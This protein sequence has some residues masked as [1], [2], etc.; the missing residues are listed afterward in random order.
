MGV[1]KKI[2]VTG[3]PLA[4]TSIVSSTN[5]F[6]KGN[7]AMSAELM[8]SMFDSIVSNGIVEGVGSELEISAYQG[9][10]ICVL[11][12]SMWINGHM[13]KTDY[14]TFITL[15]PGHHYTIAVRL[16]SSAGDVSIIAYADDDEDYMPYRGGGVYDMVLGYVDLSDETSRLREITEDMIEDTRDDDGLCGYAGLKLG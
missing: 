15:E 8:A 1:Y 16:E 4:S 6:P 14:A 2:S 13:I 10:Q 11:S 3:G 5:G 12:G 9:L 7:R